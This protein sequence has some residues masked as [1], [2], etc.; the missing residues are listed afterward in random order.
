MKDPVHNLIVAIT[1]LMC[2]GVPPVVLSQNAQQPEAPVFRSQANLVVLH[3]NVFDGRSDA[4]PDLPQSA[5]HITEDDKPQEIAF[6]AS[7]DVPVAVG[8][9]L[10][11]SSSMLT[12]RAMVVAGTEAFAT[13]SHPV[14]EA[15]TIIFNEHVRHGLPESVL[16]TQNRILLQSTLRRFPAGGK[17][18]MHDA[19]IAGLEHLEEASHQKHVLVV[20]SDGEDNAS[21]HSA[22][23]MLDRAVRS[24]ALIYTISTANLDTGVGN[25]RL[26]RKLAD[27]SGGVAYQPRSEADVVG[28]FREIA[29]NIR[30]G[31]SIGYAPTNGINDGRYRRVRVTVRAPGRNGLTVNARGGY[32]AP[33]HIHAQ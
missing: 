19:V 14:D 16:F 1:G 27:V 28:A 32:F 9:V 20:L 4:V 6:F 22:E 30:R 33:R 11:N 5:F 18:A 12:R 25:R 10:D 8:L 15:F 29:V 7:A 2:A 26:L 31:Y 21:R 3:V 23:N 13:S 24:D 17:T